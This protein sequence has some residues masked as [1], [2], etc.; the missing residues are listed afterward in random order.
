MSIIDPNIV[1][2]NEQVARRA[3]DQKDYVLCFLLAHALVESLLRAFLER[4]R[5]E[6]FHELI[7]FYKEYLE[8][9]GQ[10]EPTF[11][12]ELTELNRRRNRVIHQLWRKGYSATNEKLEPACRGAFMVYGLFIEWLET[13]K[14]EIIDLGFEYD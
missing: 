13:F 10:T 11:I 12:E 2:E 7:G 9:E 3:Y 4:S 1:R 14:P 6:T 5:K 8:A